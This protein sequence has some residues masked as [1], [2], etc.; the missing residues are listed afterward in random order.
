VFLIGIGM[1]FG[2]GHMIVSSLVHG[3]IYG[4]IFKLF[5]GLPLSVDIGI[6][7]LGIAAVWFFNRGRS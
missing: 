1:H 5:R 7:V 4:V 3:L 6:A 2:I